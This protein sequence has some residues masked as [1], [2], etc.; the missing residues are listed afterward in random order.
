[1][2]TTKFNHRAADAPSWMSPS[3]LLKGS[4][5]LVGISVVFPVVFPVCL[6][7]CVS[8]FKC[9]WAMT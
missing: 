8:L 4:T 5:R 1:V 2:P 3:R 9:D 6:P 7:S